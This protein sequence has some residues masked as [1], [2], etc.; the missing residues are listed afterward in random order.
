MTN[1]NDFR[2]YSY[3]ADPSYLIRGFD[4]SR[5][6]QAP[7][8][9]PEVEAEPRARLRVREN[10]TVKSRAELDVEQKTSTKQMIRI[11]SI[12]LLC[13]ALIAGVIC[14]MAVKNEATRELAQ[15][16]LL[17]SNAESE[18]VSLKSQLDAMVSISMIDDYA[19]NELGMSKIKGSQIQYMD[20]GEYKA[21]VKAQEK[22]KTVQ[23]QS[24]AKTSNK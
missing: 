10:T 24:S 9:R 2:R 22:A 7:K 18:N 17:L 1:T 19:V 20:V 21:K 4:L 11:A 23:N 14:S 6:S 5:G 13:M 12:A 3:Q 15:Q 8:L 16:Q